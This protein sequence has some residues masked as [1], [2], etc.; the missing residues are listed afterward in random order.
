[1]LLRS[2][3]LLKIIRVAILY[4]L[5]EII[6]SE[7]APPRIARIINRIFFWRDL[8]APR[9][10]RLRR[11]LE[12]LGP[13]FIKFGQVLST[14]RDLMP[15]DIANELT[16]LQDR[17]PPFES[18]LAVKQIEKSL[19]AHPDQLFASFER[20]P[21]ASASIAQV[22]FATLKD[23]KE[24][25]VKVLRP[26]MRDIIDHDIGLMHVAA[27]WLERLWADGRRLKAKEVVGEFD[28]YLHDELDLMREA[29]NASQ[30]RRNF[31]ESTL[32]MVPE[33]YWDYCS[34][35]VIVMERMYGIPISQT[36]RLRA[37]GV[38]LSKLSR[39]GVEIFFTQVFRDGFFHADMHPGNILVSV[40][41][42]TFGRYIAL[43]FGIVGT[44]NDYD[45]DY[46]SQNFLAF[47][48]RDYKRVAEAH[49]ES[50][51]APKETR[52]DELEAAVRACCEPIFDR[53]L[54][55]ISF[56]QV[57]LR[58]FQTSRR[59]NVEVQPQLVLLQKTLLNVEGLGRQLDPDL[60]LWKTAKPYLERWMSEQI[61]W[62]GFVE[63]LKVEVPRYSRLLPELP[64]LAH[65]ALTRYTD[66]GSQP[67]NTEL[68]RK[69]LAEQRRTNM[70]LGVIV[71]FGGGLIGG[72]I[73]IQVLM[74]FLKFY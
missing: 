59:F 61:G 33:M 16:L 70:L 60:D 8:T 36:E 51:W 72:I 63:Q 2:M 57:L 4:G 45:K 35:S 54:K 53:P 43:D 58:L 19:G 10:E 15:P 30:L 46:L 50:G 62:R 73:V 23:G 37:E 25:A 12:D 71:Y 39:D 18:E 28:K 13:I 6:A 47:F 31:A 5:D 74:H 26:G 27:D 29:A 68:I 49:I 11:A 38:D 22:H 1:M 66:G 42:E 64:R 52:V 34:S 65:Q 48:R 55:D 32:L 24:V 9:G 17:V 40:A 20:T 56:G 41:P 21:V 3:R 7:F 69:L 14:R 44:L 67:Q